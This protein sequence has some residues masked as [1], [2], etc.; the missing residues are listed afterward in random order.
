MDREGI[1]KTIARHLKEV[2]FYPKEEVSRAPSPPPAYPL[3]LLRKRRDLVQRVFVREAT[4]DL[5]HLTAK[6]AEEKV[7][8]YLS[9]MAERRFRYLRLI[10]GK[11][12]HSPEGGVLK[13]VM[14]KLLRRHPLVVEVSEAPEWNGGGGV[15]WVRLRRKIP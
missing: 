5:H 4:L 11:G 8:T 10:T 15:L 2:P 1:E 7:L 3:S 13:E 12:L 14:V 6:R 9:A